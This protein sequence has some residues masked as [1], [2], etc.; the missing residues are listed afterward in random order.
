MHL[1]ADCKGS[2]AGDKRTA[3]PNKVVEAITRSDVRYP[4]TAPPHE[5]S[6]PP[7]LIAMS[8]LHNIKIS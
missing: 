4:P 8:A 7:K 1:P 6:R 3:E 5:C 2:P